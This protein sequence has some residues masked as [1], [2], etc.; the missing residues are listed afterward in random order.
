[1]D[2]RLIVL[3]LILIPLV[4]GIGIVASGVAMNT[5][6]VILLGGVMIYLTY[7]M[8]SRRVDREIIQSDSKKATPAKMYM[9]G[10]DF[11]PTSRNVLYGYHFK[12]IA[13]AGPITGPIVAATFWGWLPSILWLILGVTFIGWAADYS[14]I[15]LSVR[16]DGNSL[17]AITYRLIAPRTRTILFVFIFF[18]LLLVAGAFMGVMTALMSAR[19]DVPL[20]LLTLAIM[21]LLAGQMLYRWKM[22]L[23]LTTVITVAIT[24]AAMA[25]GPFGTQGTTLGP[26]QSAVAGLNASIDNITGKQALFVVVDPTRADPRTPAI[27]ADGKRPATTA[28]DPATDT[29]KTLPNYLFWAIFLLVFSY[30]GTNLPIWRFA[31]PV[32]YIGFWIMLFTIG[33][34]AIGGLLAPFIASKVGTFTMAAVKPNVNLPNVFDLGFTFVAGKQWQP[35]WPMLFVTIACGAISG[36]HSLIGSVNTSRQLE[37]ETDALPVGGGGMLSENTLGLLALTAVSITG[38]SG[39]GAFAT[40]VGRLLDVVFGGGQGGFVAYGT[41]LGF[42]GFMVIVLTVVQLLFRVMRVTLTEW[43][44]DAVPLLK[45]PHVSTIISMLLALF[46]LLTGTWVYLWQLFGASNQLMAALGLLIVSI[47]LRSTGRNPLYAVVPLVFMYVTTMAAILV[48]AYNQYV[49]VLTAPAFA[50]QAIVQAGGWAMMIIS[51]LLFVCAAIIAWDG[52]KAWQRYS[53]VPKV[54]PA[55]TSE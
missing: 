19:T 54:A 32:N 28:Y 50:G 1:M 18:Y 37:Y 4:V 53:N 15:M 48:N 20:G 51:A 3:V 39:V 26:V 9:D 46:L 43:L 34:S 12:S 55:P 11:M 30:L 16:N 44:G 7:T 47:W 22:D 5:L 10:V 38:L 21:G 25:L 8:Y 40:G 33:F 13:A 41:A 14:A 17:S 23:I 6:L 27:G 2:I 29:I 35:M 52:W 36:W 45:N 24:I 31:Q 42:G 49:N